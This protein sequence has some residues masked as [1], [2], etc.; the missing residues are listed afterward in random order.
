MQEN[1]KQTPGHRR[2][3]GGIWTAAACLLLVLTLSGDRALAAPAWDAAACAGSVEIGDT[4]I[5]LGR[6][7]GIKLFSD[8]VVVTGLSNVE[9]TDSASSPGRE[10]DLR[11]GDVIT[12]INGQEVNTIE[13]VQALMAQE[14][15]EPLTLQVQ[16][17]GKSLQLT[18]QPVQNQEGA[19]QLGVWLRDSMAGIGTLTF[20][21]PQS[22]VFAALGHGISDVDTATLM[23]LETGSIMKATVSDVKKGLSGEPGELH[24]VFD[25]Q[26]DLG[27]LYAN[28]QQ[29]IFGTLD[30]KQLVQSGQGV[31]IA[32]RDQVHTG[33]AT[34]LSNI[35][36]DQVEEYE[37][38]ILTL[39]PEGDGDTRNLMLQVTDPR[40]LETTG[41]IV[42]GMSGSPILQDGRLVGAVTHVLINEPSRGYGILAENMV[43]TAQNSAQAA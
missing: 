23:P 38:E 2:L 24:G 28:T 25:L 42:Q 14:Q 5:P 17:E 26:H 12:H 30:D 37:I 19:Y 4:V 43:K 32:S 27:T 21:D 9:S 33:K 41:G 3:G 16:R 7:V 31:E 6:A 20:Y 35:A 39:Y 29:G 15:G 1:T 10:G 40:L 18:V 13:G 36:G 8:G 34:I 22:G 11:A